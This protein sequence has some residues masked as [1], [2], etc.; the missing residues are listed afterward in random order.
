MQTLKFKLEVITP[1]FIAGAHPQGKPEIRPPSIRGALR[2]W[3][4]AMMGGVV[5][6]DWRKVKEFESQVFGDT[7]QA[8]RIIIKVNAP[9][10]TVRNFDFHDKGIVY[11][12][13]GLAKTKTTVARKYIPTQPKYEFDM[14]ICLRE[15]RYKNLLIGSMWLLGN[16]G[17]LGSRV[18]R[19]FGGLRT[20]M[21]EGL[22][23]DFQDLFEIP[24]ED[25]IVEYFQKSIKKIRRVFCGSTGRT[26][27]PSNEPSFSV[28]S[29]NYWVLKILD[30]RKTTGQ[31]AMNWVGERFR[32]FREDRSKKPHTRI[33]KTGKSISYYIGKDYAE[34]KKLFIRGQRPHKLSL[35]IFGLP[36]QFQFQSINKNAIVIGEEHERR[37][38]PLFIRV[39]KINDRYYRVC[40]MKFRARF[41]SVGEK[42]KMEESR[43]PKNYADLSPVDWS[44][45]DGF[46]KQFPGK[47]I[48]IL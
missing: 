25:K 36:L 39:F 29:P 32:K 18:R 7:E 41:L 8:S 2:F 6:G 16:L 5:G 42:L 4:R 15:E 23:D 48:S 17:G 11:L 34:A 10:P 1:M 9:L 24:T 47:E 37:S 35:P 12:G 21:A 31:E 33:T 43:N 38:S 30:Q 46:L 14:K 13:Y 19:G 26:I 3:F 45:F 40:L 27:V 20:N 44:V 28:I 22:P